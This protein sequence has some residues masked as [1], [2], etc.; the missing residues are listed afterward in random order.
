[1]VAKYYNEGQKQSIMKWRATNK[2][3]YND[4]MSEYHKKF[5]AKNVE[6]LRKKRM[7]IYYFQKEW[8]RICEILFSE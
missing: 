7:D 8:K 3:E 6:R 2:S 5:Y 1:M 4:Y